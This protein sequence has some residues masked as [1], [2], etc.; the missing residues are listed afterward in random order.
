M[1]CPVL[2]I[3]AFFLVR[4]GRVEES[5][6]T[7]TALSVHLLY[8]A[9]VYA[10]PDSSLTVHF[11]WLVGGTFFLSK[12]GPLFCSVAAERVGHSS[13]FNT[14]FTVSQDHVRRPTTLAQV[15]GRRSLR[16]AADV[17]AGEAAHAS[18]TGCE[19]IGVLIVAERVAAPVD[20]ERAR[21]VGEHV[22]RDGA[23][24]GLAGDDDGLERGLSRCP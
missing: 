4:L 19:C 15:G 13:C 8:G 23:D 18:A 3:G 12:P 10:V 9:P 6:G 20:I 16:G 2:G 22:G 24:E 14:V 17:L 1:L 7:T 11:L 21:S 5:G